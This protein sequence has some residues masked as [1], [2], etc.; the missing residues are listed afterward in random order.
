[1]ENKTNTISTQLAI[2]LGEQ[3]VRPDLFFNTLNTEMGE[4]IDAMPQTLPLPAE[5]PADIPRVIGNSSFGRYN[6]NI[7]LS[8]IDFV[9]N[10]GPGED[11][12]K[13]VNDFRIKS[14]TL[15]STVFQK[16]AIVRMGLVGNYYIPN[17]NPSALIAKMYLNDKNKNPDEISIRINK[18]DNFKGVSINNVITVNPGVVTAPNFSGDAVILQLDYNSE[19][20]ADALNE[21]LALSL[22]KEKSSAYYSKNL[23]EVYGL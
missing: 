15:I 3:I 8:R 17:K 6:L 10:Y 18:K 4:I 22:F 7:S 12:E 20:R 1:M 19:E 5:A 11:I 23:A 2:F 14:N 16:Y 13:A 9:Q 21:G